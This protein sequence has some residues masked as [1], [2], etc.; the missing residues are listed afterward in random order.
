MKI[1]SEHKMEWLIGIVCAFL[2]AILSKFIFFT[3][4][5]PDV[6]VPFWLL[7]ILACAPFG[8]LA[9]GIY[10][11]KVKD[12]SNRSF[13]VER[14]NICGKHFVNCEFDGTELIYDAS[15]PTSMSHCKLS[16]MRIS[17]TGSASDTVGYLT[18]LYSDPAF[19][20]IVE[21]TFENI[22]S[23]GLELAQRN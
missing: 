4:S 11:R 19:R 20:P 22:K 1:F 6:S 13:G 21:K 9:A 3:S 15:A 16:S 10:G 18:A 14:V 7:I 23:R 8:Y 17:F 2:P 5:V 12:I